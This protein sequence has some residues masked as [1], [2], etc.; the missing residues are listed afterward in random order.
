MNARRDGL[1]DDV[2]NERGIDEALIERVVRAF[3]DR[4]RSDA[5]LGPIFDDRITDWEP[6]LQRMFAFWSSVILMSGRY[7]GQPMVKH[8]FL[9]VDA[10]HFDRWL[11]LFKET[12]RE[13]CPPGA[14]AIFADRAERIA[15][16]LELGIAMQSGQMLRKGERLRR[17]DGEVYLPTAQQR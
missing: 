8:A 9:P 11:D 16:S 6:H 2:R 15:A 4:I 17:A 13:L 12:V 5:L 10:R 7:S 14:A 3:Y 1:V